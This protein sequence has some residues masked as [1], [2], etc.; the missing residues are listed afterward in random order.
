MFFK[1]AASSWSLMLFVILGIFSIASF[2]I[3][4]VTVT[5]YINS[6]A[7]SLADVTRTI[8]IWIVGIIVTLT[9]GVD[10]V[11]YKW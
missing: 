5:K 4:G 9:V 11:N 3:C 7:R 2:N 8:I 1:E 10:H 6:L